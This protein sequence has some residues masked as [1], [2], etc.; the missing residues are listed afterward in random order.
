MKKNKKV[1][2]IKDVK[3]DNIFNF[4]K[5]SFSVTIDR[6]DKI[7]GVFLETYLKLLKSIIRNFAQNIAKVI[8]I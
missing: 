8:T 4:L 2:W 3:I 6:M 1:F 5:G 7:F